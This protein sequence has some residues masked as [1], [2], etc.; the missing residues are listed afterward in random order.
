MMKGMSI[1]TKVTVNRWC[2]ALAVCFAMVFSV[3]AITYTVAKDGS[4]TFTT[5]M[6]AI[7]VAQPGD[8]VQILDAATYPEQV[9]IDSTKNGLTLCSKNPT[10]FNKP[11]IV[12]RDIT[13]VGPKTYEESLIDSLIRFDRNGALQLLAVRNVTI[14]GIAIDG[15]SPFSFGYPS[16][17][18]NKD[19]MQHGNGAIS[20][21]MSGAIHIKNCSISNAYFGI[22]FK[23]RNQGGIFGNPN[24]ADNEPWKVVPLSGYGKT[25]NHIIE[26]NRIH[27]NSVGMFFESSW[28]L[29]TTIR[30]NLIYENHHQS[31]A[32]ATEV[33]N[34]TSDGNNQPGGAIMVKDLML[35][36]MAIY[37]NT[38]WHNFLELIGHWKVGYHHLLFNNIFAVPYRY[39]QAE[40]IVTGTYMDMS[41]CFPN[42][43]NNCVFAAH[44][45]AP[46]PNYVS[47]FNGMPNP[48]SVN[49]QIPPGSL[50]TAAA[51]FPAAANIRW[52]E[53]PFIS[54]D[55]AS[56]NFLSPDWS[57]T[58]V[59]QFIIDQGWAASG[60]LDP[61]GTPADIGAIPQGGGRAADVST[62]IP[63]MPIMLNGNTAT[64]TMALSQRIGNMAAPSIKLHR[65]VGNLPYD[66]TA[67]SSNWTAGVITAGNVR[68]VAPPAAPVIVGGNTYTFTLPVAQT[69]N[70]GF[71]EMIINGTGSNSLPFSSTV[72]FIPYRKLEYKFVI[73]V[74]DVTS[75]A[76]LTQV[77]AGDTVVLR[78]RA[79]KADG[80]IFPNT[81]NPVTVSLQSGFTLLSTAV[82]PPVAVTL[83]GGVPG[84]TAGSRSN[85]MFTRVPTTT[86]G[87]EYVIGAGQWV[88]GTNI[89]PFFG[90]SAGIKIL[91]GPPEKVVFQNPPSIKFQANIPVID[92]GIPF[93][94]LLYVY[95]RFDNRCDKPTSVNL[96]SLNPTIGN[97]IGTPP[98][99]I[100]TD[101]TGSGVF[102]VEV[103]NG[104]LGELFKIRADLP[105]KLPD[106]AYL[107][108]GAPRD[109]LWIFYSDTA[110]Y[111]LSTR[112]QGT[113]GERLP[114]VIMCGKTAKLDSVTTTANFA[115]SVI[116]ATAGLTFYETSAAAAP[117]TSF[118]L[119]NGRK[120]LWVTSSVAISNG[121]FA[122]NPD[123]TNTVLGSDPRDK[124]YFIKPLVAIDSAFYYTNNGFGRVDRV[125][126]SF[127]DTLSFVP[128][129]MIFYW[130]SK[131]DAVPNRRVVT[132]AGGGMTLDAADHRHITVTLATPF[133]DEITAGSTGEFLGTTWNRPNS[134]PA[135][136]S[137]AT[138][139]KILDRV[140]PLAMTALLV[141]RIG[142]G[143]GN[144]TLFVSF[145]EPIVP[146][147]LIAAG[148]IS[149]ILKKAGVETPLTVSEQILAATPTSPN[150]YRVVVTGPAA[151]A[152][153]DSLRLQP[154][155]PI[156]DATL[157]APHLNNRPVPISIKA[158]PAT[159]LSAK[160]QDRDA[161][162]NVDHVVIQF[163]KKVAL[164]D[165]IIA[166]DWGLGKLDTVAPTRLSFATPDSIVDINTITFFTRLNGPKT[167]GT[168]RALAS[169]VSIPGEMVQGDVADSAAPA[170]IDTTRY[171]PGSPIPTNETTSYPDTLVTQF[172]EPI[173]TTINA[174]AMPFSLYS[175]TIRTPYSFTVAPGFT[176]AQNRATF[177][178]TTGSLSPATIGFPRTGDSVWINTAGGIADLAGSLPQINPA[179]RRVPLK[180]MLKPSLRIAIS[181]NPF[182]EVTPIIISDYPSI[183]GKGIAIVLRPIGRMGNVSNITE[184]TVTIY[185]A[186]GNTVVPKT[187]FTPDLTDNI[188]YFIWNGR[189]SNGRAVGSG[190]Y[191][192]VLSYTDINGITTPG[193]KRIGVKR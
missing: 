25:G 178:V 145:S 68:T 43:M 39:L 156:T 169:Y 66:G 26:Y 148:G 30:Y 191:L 88:D 91:P 124:I 192:A 187:A 78:I 86:G 160:Y 153:G 29:G 172:S 150:R 13:N 65:W 95:D 61:D 49:N 137:E 100:T 82:D 127:K 129:S 18:T 36:P 144:D 181:R 138:N 139:F 11:K 135:T 140:G 143:V 168:M 12:Y 115:F 175:I 70:Y 42:R 79:Y 112:L 134:S 193:I 81:V 164:A 93:S 142:G 186:V 132:T 40:T 85:V 122:V 184:A 185:D 123:S 162:G 136:P 76:I 59:Q 44:V 109:R 17:W 54:T 99:T 179:N 97:I 84:T 32:F 114:V 72:G 133:P 56:A 60:V 113:V 53:T 38:F 174:S 73:D 48:P 106:T 34:K 90:T 87:L 128:D 104:K 9:I 126:V 155:G 2:A 190:A 163:A 167:S 77:R 157:N 57:D 177:I 22:N 35:S 159:I 166:L 55:S 189:N 20:V 165:C 182:S 118:T 96:S 67:W 16:I 4:G 15:G 31:N 94:G 170:L 33:K 8:I 120:T 161:D 152:V 28:D 119:V 58:L 111:D 47:I 10:A 101:T 146:A 64:V 21:W 27:H 52:L 75:G 151:P 116:G 158:V 183:T 5:I 180:V 7:K 19:P 37:N 23:D 80:T 105:A 108:V 121:Q 1:M 188:F 89:L 131:L 117:A 147:S 6:A 130:P 176:T 103:T 125:E 46:D 62:I 63:T 141:E 110:G 69:G 51:S 41:K 24:P 14:D 92:P 171:Y 3:Q 98:V 149:L 50:L 45:Q 107:K 173:A 74:L 83:P 71:L 102:Q 154:G